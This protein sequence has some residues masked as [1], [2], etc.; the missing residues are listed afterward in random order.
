[1]IECHLVYFKLIFDLC[2][3][4]ALSES[5][6]YAGKTVGDIIGF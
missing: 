4:Y 1:M 6:L 3:A 5:V 2:V